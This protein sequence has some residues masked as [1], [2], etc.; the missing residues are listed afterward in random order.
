MS[1]EGAVFF[2]D[3]Y[4]ITRR[5]TLNLGVRWE[6]TGSS[7]IDGGFTSAVLDQGYGGYSVQRAWRSRRSM[8]SSR[9]LSAS[10]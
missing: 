2:K 1:N 8:R 10:S 7:Y 3:D 6:Y 4:K 9:I 5:L